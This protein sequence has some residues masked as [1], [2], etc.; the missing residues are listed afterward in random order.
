M[1]SS[2]PLHGINKK[3]ALNGKKTLIFATQHTSIYVFYPNGGLFP[4]KNVSYEM[5]KPQ[6]FSSGKGWKF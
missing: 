2:P 6:L 5:K 4:N 1:I 3:V